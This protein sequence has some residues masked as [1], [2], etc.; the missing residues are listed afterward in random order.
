MFVDNERYIENYGERERVCVWV[1]D[2]LLQIFYSLHLSIH[3]YQPI[4]YRATTIR[5][6]A[7]YIIWESN[8]FKTKTQKPTNITLICINYALCNTPTTTTTTI[9]FVLIVIFP[10][11]IVIIHGYVGIGVELGTVVRVRNVLGLERATCS[12]IIVRSRQRWFLKL[13]VTLGSKVGSRDNPIVQPQWRLFK[14]MV[15]MTYIIQVFEK[16]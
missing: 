13:D 4:L 14:N 5:N 10:L 8:S 9:I 1:C 11:T 7:V 6:D 16:I 2:F 12:G 3:V 15:K